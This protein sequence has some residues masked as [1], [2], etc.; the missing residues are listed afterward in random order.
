MIV[1]CV[2]LCCPVCLGFSDLSTSFRLV[3]ALFGAADWFGGLG[4][5][6]CCCGE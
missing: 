6:L 5:L 1:W 3:I 4:L 2:A